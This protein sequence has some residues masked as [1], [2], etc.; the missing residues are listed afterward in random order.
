MI[1]RYITSAALILTSFVGW[2]AVDAPAHAA[3]LS[4]FMNQELAWSDCG[5]LQCTW[6]TVPLDYA[7]PDGETI[8]LRVN[9]DRTS[10]PSTHVGSIVINPGGPGVS[11][12]GFTSYV[13]SLLSSDVTAKY[14]VV[15][16]DPRSVGKSDPVKCMSDAYTVKWLNTDITPD[17]TSEEHTLLERASRIGAGCVKYTPAITMHDSTLDAARDLDII[18]AALREEKLNYLGFSYGTYLGTQYAGLFPAHVGRLVLDGAL[19]PTLDAMALSEGQSDGFQLAVKRFMSDCLTRASCPFSGSTSHALKKLNAFLVG[20]DDAPLPARPGQPLVQSQGIGAV[21]GSLY[22]TWQWPNLRDA[23]ASALNKGN[24][25]ALQNIAF[26]STDRTV[27]GRFLT[28]MQSAFLAIGCTDTVAPPKRS[29]L[30]KAAKQWATGVKVPE[31]A[32]AMSWGNAPCAYWPVSA[33]TPANPVRADGTPPILVIGTKYDPATPLSWAKALAH[34]LAAGSLL[35]YNGDGHTAF[36]GSSNCVDSAVDQ[37]F[38]TG[39]PPPDGK[40][41]KH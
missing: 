25:R 36:G 26:N 7:Q 37:F 11:G 38:L 17:S 41:C 34:Q 19:D 3:D 30:A 12:L 8:Q 9:R 29:G 2:G 15:G 14:D 32:R 5:G 28:N 21:F 35:Q 27:S 33:A 24:G 13:A 22:A 16:F 10:N 40:V 20:L 23:L 18:R 6:V 39:T 1:R 31:L 4:S